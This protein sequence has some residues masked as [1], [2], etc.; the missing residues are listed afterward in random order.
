[1]KSIVNWE[2]RCL[3]VGNGKSGGERDRQTEAVYEAKSVT[4]VR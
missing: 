4:H 3:I 2:K 1:M